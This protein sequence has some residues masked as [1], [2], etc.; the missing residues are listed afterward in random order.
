MVYR[1]IV[2]ENNIDH[3]I[4]ITNESQYLKLRNKGEI[5][6]GKEI[7]FLEED[8]INENK[9]NSNIY[10]GIA[11]IFL[12]LILSSSL[13]FPFGFNF[14]EN[15][16]TYAIVSLDINP[17]LQFEINKK[18]IVKKVMSLD[19]DGKSIIDDSMVGMTI[20]DAVLLGVENAIEKEYINEQNNAILIARV[21]TKDNDG[22]KS[23]IQEDIR[24]SI[25]EKVNEEIELIYISPNKDT[26]KEAKN[27]KI[28]VG[29][30][31]IYKIISEK[32]ANTSIKEVEQKS[33]T[34]II[35]DNR[36]LFKDSKIQLKNNKNNNLR[37]DQKEIEKYRKEEEKEQ[38][39]DRKEKGKNKEKEYKEQKNQEDKNNK[40]ENKNDL[41]KDSD[42]QGKE[43]RDNKARDNKNRKDENQREKDKL[44]KKEKTDNNGNINRNSAKENRN[45]NFKD[46]NEKKE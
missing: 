17:S 37:K 35:N 2:M 40:R 26:I 1:G 44:D 42:N 31:E 39:K 38:R 23:N 16:Q 25:E 46:N 14:L 28:S 3:I 8:I 34:A 10:R 11:A 33:I 12:I 19:E 9:K 32:K 5:N 15:V 18:E 29:K 22:T 24:E 27:N 36:E 4:I 20:K 21:V 43:N 30:Y 45:P 13:I 41:S 7:V 6:I